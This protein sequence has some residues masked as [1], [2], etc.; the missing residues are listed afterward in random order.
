MRF[1]VVAFDLDGTLYP[2]FRLFIRLLPFLTRES[3]LLMAMGKARRLLRKTG[4]YQGDFYDNQARLMA[5]Y[6]KKPV[7]ETRERTEKLIYLGW[8]RHFKKIKLFPHVKET[9]ELFRQGGIKMGILSDFPPERKLEYLGLGSYW[10]A[11]VCSEESG[12]LKPD[13]LSFLDLAKKLNA[14]AGEILYVGNRLSYDVLGAK[15]AGMKTALIQSPWKKLTRPPLPDFV[16]H[17]YRQLQKY[18]LN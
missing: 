16:F 3:P 17:D 7:P 4:A 14:E 12:R 1:S 13:P 9:L 15:G 18:V 6:L 10:D 8:E 11:V 2:D 5:A